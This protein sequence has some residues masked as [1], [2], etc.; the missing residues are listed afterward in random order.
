MMGRDPG[1][2]LVASF[3]PFAVVPEPVWRQAKE[4]ARA[5][6][7]LY[8]FDV[9]IVENEAAPDTFRRWFSAQNDE[10]VDG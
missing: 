6:F 8:G 3:G 2:K 10:P 9:T 1:V 7:K 4:A 5:A